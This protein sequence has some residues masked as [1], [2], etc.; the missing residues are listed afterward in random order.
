MRSPLRFL[1]ALSGVVLVSTL[2][3][4][5][6]VRA[7]G[8]ANPGCGTLVWLNGNQYP[9]GPANPH[10]PEDCQNTGQFAITSLHLV[11]SPS[12]LADTIGVGDYPGLNV[13]LQVS[14]SETWFAGNG[15]IYDVTL[16]TQNLACSD[17]VQEVHFPYVNLIAQ[18]DGSF[19]FRPTVAGIDLIYLYTK[20]GDVIGDDGYLVSIPIRSVDFDGD[21]DCDEADE[22]HLRNAMVT[23]SPEADL[24]FDGVV[25]AADLAIL[26]REERR[27]DANGQR[28]MRGSCIG[29]NKVAYS[30]TMTIYPPGAPTN[31]S[32]TQLCYRWQFQWTASGDDGSTGTAYQYDI[33]TSSSPI[34]A[35]N[36]A[37]ATPLTAPTPAAS[38]T[39]QSTAYLISA[40]GLYFAI[41]A[42]DDSGEW[43]DVASVSVPNIT[44]S[45][46][47]SAT[48]NLTATRH[49]D[50]TAGG[51][52]TLQWT[53]AGDDGTTG[54][55]T[56]YDVR[57]STAPITS[58]NFAGAAAVTA[59][60]V[61]PGGTVVSTT[62]AM[63]ACTRYYFALKTYDDRGNASALSNVPTLLSFCQQPPLQMPDDGPP[64]APPTLQLTVRTPT[65]SSVAVDLAVPAS[66]SGAAVKLALYDVLGRRVAT[67]LDGAATSGRR[68]LTWDLTTTSGARAPMG[69]YAARLLIGS[70]VRSAKFQIIR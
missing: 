59:P 51:S 31:L 43:S 16:L 62:F 23:Q 2:N 21:G 15:T 57:Y 52:A 19:L 35:Q 65:P 29:E 70:E 26:T 54:T 68:T 44:D 30:G 10:V 32:I 37:S 4:I 18:Q 20:F 47:P 42:M 55:P 17:T 27:R 1:V 53:S 28:Y 66:L 50:G 6:I 8:S 9:V 12:G 69:V 41:R 13:R 63:D 38:G 34:T 36:F 33:R 46:A 58:G 60:A 7:Q 64:A 61:A 3:S 22:A 25:D 56:C 39:V 14:S 24:N 67:L 11:G 45:T 5:P 48:T 49:T 40:T